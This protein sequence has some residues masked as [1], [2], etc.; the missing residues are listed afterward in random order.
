MIDSDREFIVRAD[1]FGDIK[2][3]QKQ[4]FW[5]PVSRGSLF[6]SDSGVNYR[7]RGFS[8][9]SLE[10]RYNKIIKVKIL[11]LN[12]KKNYWI[13]NSLASP[14][15]LLFWNP[16]WNRFLVNIT[17]LDKRAQPREAFFKLKT[18]KITEDTLTIL[19]AFLSSPQNAG[20]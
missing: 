10:I 2:S 8:E 14:Y 20:S 1:F 6:F 7:E 3:N 4:S 17:H 9:N 13:R 15:Y 11:S 18:R 16:F 19:K 5:L 12:P